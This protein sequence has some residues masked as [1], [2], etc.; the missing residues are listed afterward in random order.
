M[1]LKE[2]KGCGKNV[3][4]K[5]KSCPHCGEP[6]QRSTQGCV[7]GC[8]VL[9]LVLFVGALAMYM[10]TIQET[11]TPTTVSSPVSKKTDTINNSPTD[12]KKQ[13]AIDFCNADVKDNF[14]ESVEIEFPTPLTYENDNF[15]FVHYKDGKEVITGGG[16]TKVDIRCTI[17][18]NT[19]IIT[20]MNINGNDKTKPYD[21]TLVE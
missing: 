3:S 1:A 2:C 9:I 4:K 5:A 6:F 21:H 17:N 11:P 12:A 15:Y 19:Y 18:K 13:M 7:G 10:S 16:T 20:L 14:H 8:S